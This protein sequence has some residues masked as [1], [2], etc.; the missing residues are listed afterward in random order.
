MTDIKTILC[1]TDL[2]NESDEALRYA[3]ALARL[4]KAKVFVYH[5]AE[6]APFAATDEVT[7]RVEETITRH[8][9]WM[10]PDGVEW[11]P[12][13][14]MVNRT[15]GDI[16]GAITLA[17]AE[18]G[19]GLIVMESR[20]HPLSAAVFGSTAEAVCRNAACPVLVTHPQEHEFV[21]AASGEVHLKRILVADDF[22][23]FS[24]AALKFGFSLAQEYQSE[25][26]IIHV[27]PPRHDKQAQTREGLH[28]HDSAEAL[29]E[30]RLKGHVPPEVE[31]WCTVKSVVRE[32]RPDHEIVA[33]AKEQDVDLICVG[34][35]GKGKGWAEFL[36]STTD[37]VLRHT[38]CPAL[39]AR[40]VGGGS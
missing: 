40:P 3:F 20:R 36:G 12:A 1:S 16:A 22:S 39:V 15:T 30:H 34:S 19:A 2:S 31:L 17:A 10:N 14:G 38:P 37:R 29:V 28:L 9:N 5:C 7:S 8:V 26:H 32:G 23:E 6:V 25:L 33:Y 18:R 4:Y 35:H 27:Q 24:T 13:I 11:E 21:D